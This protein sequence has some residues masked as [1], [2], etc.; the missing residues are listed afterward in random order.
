MMRGVIPRSWHPV[1][2]EEPEVGVILGTGAA[3][4]LSGPKKG[5]KAKAPIGFRHPAQ[6]REVPPIR[7]AGRPSGR[8]QT[9]PAS[10]RKRK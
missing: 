5:A 1:E 3:S 7:N 9:P 8:T 10:T 2:W 4:V 6:M